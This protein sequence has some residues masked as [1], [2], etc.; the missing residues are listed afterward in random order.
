M[1]EFALIKQYFHQQSTPDKGVILDKGDDCALLS[2]PIHQSLAVTTDTLV[3]G[4]HF[5]PEIDPFALG[6]RVLA[7]NLSDLAAM[8][9]NPKWFNLALTLPNFDADWLKAFSQGLFNLASQ[10]QCHLIGGDTTKGPL[11]ITISAFGEVEASKALTRCAAQVGD[12]I[13]VSGTIG[14]A[15]AGLAAY[16][17]KNFAAQRIVSEQSVMFLKQRF[18][19]PQPRVSL[20]KKLLGIAN[21]ALDISDGL[22]ADL[23][24]ICQRSELNA[25]IHCESLPLAQH[26]KD[27]VGF[28]Q[29]LVNALSGGDDYELCFTAPKAQRQTIKNIA[30]DLHLPLTL[31]GEMLECAEGPQPTCSVLNKGRVQNLAKHGFQ[32]F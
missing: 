20:G 30:N 17:D 13:Y 3:S 11:S 8:G 15:A 25:V 31:I 19:L 16:T 4:R 32:H 2:P 10:F 26:H 21:A 23:N 12:D 29:A 24:H 28:E 22:V 27:A 7:T 18:D 9:A 6:H 1:N 5:L 14:D